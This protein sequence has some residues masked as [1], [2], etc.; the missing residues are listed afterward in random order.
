MFLRK[1]FAS[2]KARRR[3]SQQ[4][5]DEKG[6]LISRRLQELQDVTKPKQ[7]EM[8]F[9]KARGG[10]GSSCVHLEKTGT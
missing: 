5:N 3:S 8:P 9:T 2:I 10:N 7:A 1:F 6:A 4:H